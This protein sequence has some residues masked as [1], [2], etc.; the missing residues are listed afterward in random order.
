ML[1]GTGASITF[2][3]HSATRQEQRHQG[4]IDTS[5]RAKIQYSQYDAFDPRSAIDH[6]LEVPFPNVE[7]NT[8]LRVTPSPFGRLAIP[9]YPLIVHIAETA[10]APAHMSNQRALTES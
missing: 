2:P 1:C 9:G 4:R 10:T 7:R 5:T 6:S 8:A 3:V